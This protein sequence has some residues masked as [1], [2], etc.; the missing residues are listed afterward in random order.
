MD[1]IQPAQDR[2]PEWRFLENTINFIT[3]LSIGFSARAL[4]LGGQDNDSPEVSL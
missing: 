2:V 4:F 3:I 1:W